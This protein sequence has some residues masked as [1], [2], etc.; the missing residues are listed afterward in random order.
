MTSFRSWKARQWAAFVASGAL[1]ALTLVHSEASALK[2][3]T[4]H[5]THCMPVPDTGCGSF[6]GNRLWNT[7]ATDLKL[8]CAVQDD[9]SFQKT[10]LT[11]WIM[12]VHDNSA[13]SAVTARA[14]V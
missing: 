6:S 7:C 5:P 10:E 8:Y 14:C 3:T 1:S 13:T 9:D 12:W 2:M 4:Q 11:T